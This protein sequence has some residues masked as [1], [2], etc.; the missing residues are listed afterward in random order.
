LNKKGTINRER[1]GEKDG[2]SMLRKHS[3]FIVMPHTGKG[4]I[5]DAGCFQQI[6]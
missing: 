2:K 5:N 1:V 3:S 4:H 6:E